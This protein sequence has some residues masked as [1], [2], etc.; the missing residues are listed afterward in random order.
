MDIADFKKNHS[1]DWIRDYTRVGAVIPC[2]LCQI[3][4]STLNINPTHEDGIVADFILLLAKPLNPAVV[5]LLVMDIPEEVKIEVTARCNMDCEFCYNHNTFTRNIEDMPKEQ[6]LYFIDEVH[7]LGVAS[8]KFSGGEPLMRDDILE[9]L[10]YA[11]YKGLFVKLNTNGTLIGDPS[12]FSGLVDRFLLPFHEPVYPDAARKLLDHGFDAC[13]MTVLTKETVARLEEFFPLARGFVWSLT[14]PVPGKDTPMPIN[15][16][17]VALFIEKMLKLDPEG[18]I[19]VHALPFCSY[20]P[21]KVSRYSLGAQQCGIATKLVIGPNGTIKPCYSID[22]DLGTD[23]MSAW[24]SEFPAQM[25]ALKLLPDEC[26][27]CRYVNE[28]LGGCRFA[29][30]LSASSQ[31]G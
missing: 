28:C 14:R 17:D 21:H 9:V 23:I 27:K 22:M 29:A 24:E 25:R 16:E 11:K 8:V 1:G 5:F 15:N 19:K 4:D 26:Q 31:D 18:R 13:L 20:E 10:G 2:P 12:R 6:I 30:W 7:R 3:I